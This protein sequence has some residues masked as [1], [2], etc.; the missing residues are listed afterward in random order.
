MNVNV[1]SRPSLSAEAVARAL[2]NQAMEVVE[3]K[4]SD[5]DG[6]VWYLVRYSVEE[7]ATVQGWIRTGE[8]IIEGTECPEA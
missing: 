4:V 8:Y 5:A 3:Q 6:R 7:G 1:R 2:T